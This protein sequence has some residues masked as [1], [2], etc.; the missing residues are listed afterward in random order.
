[1]ELPLSLYPKQYRVLTSPANEI[2][3]GGAA[4]GGKSH[5][6]RVL[7]VMACTFVPGCQVYLFRRNNAD[8]KKNHL[9]SPKGFAWLLGPLIESKLV[10]LVEGE[11][12][13]WNGSKIHLCHLNHKKDLKN[14]Q[15]A[16][17]H[18]LLIDE[19]TQLEEDEYKYLRSR[20]RS[21]GLVIPPAHLTGGI[22][23]RRIIPSVVA[24]CNPGGKG[25]SFFKESFVDE[26]AYTLRQMGKEE[27][28][29]L[30]QFI[31]ATL[32]D[33]PAMIEDDPLY[34]AR[35]LGLGGKL[36]QAM[37]WGSWDILEGA[38]FD[39]FDP[40][41]HVVRPQRVPEWLRRFRTYD[42]GYAKP[43][44]HGWWAI[45]DGT[46]EIELAGGRQV[47]PAKGSLWLY[48]EWYGK[49]KANVG[50]KLEP[51]FIA[52]GVLSR[53][54]EGE[55]FG[56]SLADRYF[57]NRGLGKSVQEVWAEMGL[58][59]GLAN[60]DRA[61]GWM[62]MRMRL[63]PDPETDLPQ[64]YFVE[65]SDTVRT[66]PI[67][68]YDERNA[69]DLD[70]DL[71][72]HAVDMVRMACMSREIARSK[73]KSRSSEFFTTRDLERHTRAIEEARGVYN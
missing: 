33:N 29:M 28:G 57:K 61:Q 1:M 64:I 24:T 14:Y 50:V 68:Q 70:S 58:H 20:T 45:L 23:F 38:F 54:M 52:A 21:V 49:T 44:A 47:T 53:Q 11:I 31:P 34:E 73:P 30:R 60:D 32:E 19:A 27:G 69:E 26:G 56:Y 15:G 55:K 41:I 35:L 36:A 71:E 66:I 5:L 63:V 12:R 16:E 59:Y 13:F 22:D 25:H 40:H 37:R 48:R 7:A 43:F 62:Q 39:T 10:K 67:M 51:Q 8:L 46:T 6:L 17:I 9:D 2:V 18:L 72:D 65:G 3:Y 42:H 4:G